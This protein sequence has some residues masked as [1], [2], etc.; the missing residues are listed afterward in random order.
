MTAGLGRNLVLPESAGC[1]TSRSAARTGCQQT[2]IHTVGDFLE[3]LRMRIE[4]QTGITRMH[5]LHNG[6]PDF[7]RIAA[8]QT[9]QTVVMLVAYPYR[10]GILR[11]DAAEPD[12]GIGGG[13]TGLAAGFYTVKLN[14]VGGTVCGNV[15]QTIEHIIIRAD[16]GKALIRV[17]GILHYGVAFAV[18]H[19][20]VGAG[21]A[22]NTVIDEGRETARHL[23]NGNAVRQCAERQ[24][25]KVDIRLHGAVLI[26]AAVYQLKAKLLRHEFV[27]LLRSQLFEQLCRNGIERTRHTFLDRHCT[28]GRI[29]AVVHRPRIAFLILYERTVVNR[30]VRRSNTGIH[31]RTI[32]RQRLDRGTRLT[33]CVRRVREAAAAGLFTA[34]AGNTNDIALLVRDDHGALRNFAVLFGVREIICVSP[35]LIECILH[36]GV[37]GRI[38]VQTAGVNHVLRNQTGISLFGHQ[39]VDHVLDDFIGEVA[40]GGLDLLLI[41]LVGAVVQLLC[42]GSLVLL[43]RDHLLIEHLCKDGL[44]TL[45]YLFWMVINVVN[46]RVVGET[47]QHGGF[48]QIQLRYI[49]VKVLHRRS[50]HA[51]AVVAQ[52]DRVQVHDQNTVLVVNL[53]FEC[54]RAE[55]LVYLALY[56]VIVVSRDVFDQLL[57]YRGAAVLR[58]AEQ[59][60]LDRTDRAHPVYTVV[61]VKALVLDCNDCV[62][63]GIRNLVAVHPFTVFLALDGFVQRVFIGI[64]F[65]SID[66]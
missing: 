51:V 60:A 20:G 64:R 27:G 19:L 43:L 34:T 47:C 45:L 16:I 42:Y 26:G 15:L 29:F 24:R 6:Q 38:D 13:G 5:L 21:T 46:R 59:P 36:L 7:R 32:G 50:L 8:V 53:F 56:R 49:L 30:G 40:V 41:L 54:K 63:E 1:S 62:L 9:I 14:A 3:I 35:D 28:A 65:L 11:R 55:N 4:Y 10:T 18:R 25:C 17:R 58:A 37:D 12:I 31:R 39:V 44:L 61:L 22:V 2:G 33:A 66:E 57:R 52:I 48:C 23:T